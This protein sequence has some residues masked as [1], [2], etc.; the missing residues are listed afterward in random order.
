MVRASGLEVS[1]SRMV[2]HVCVSL[3][4]IV[5]VHIGKPEHSQ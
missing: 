2:W 1:G 3:T 5:R 4:H